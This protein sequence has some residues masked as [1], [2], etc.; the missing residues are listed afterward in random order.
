MIAELLNRLRY[1]IHCSS[2]DAELDD[3]GALADA[4]CAGKRIHVYGELPRS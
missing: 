1:L 4:A 2:F 3:E